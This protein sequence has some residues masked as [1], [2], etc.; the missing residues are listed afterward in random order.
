MRDTS[1]LLQYSARL[2]VREWKKFVLP[3]L[4]L[5][6]TAIVLLVTLLLSTSST[7][8]LDNQARELLGGDIV[9]ESTKPL[10]AQTTWSTLGITPRATSTQIEF[11]GT[12]QSNERT[13]PFS[14]KAVSGEYPLYGTVSLTDGPLTT[15]I[16]GAIYL[17]AAGAERLSVT[18]GS[19]VSFGNQDFTLA[20]IIKSE[21]TALLSGFRFLPQ[22][23]ITEMSFA[24]TGIDPNLLRAEYSIL[25]KTDSVTQAQ[26]SATEAL[27]ANSGGLISTRIAGENRS[28]LQRG[29]QIVADFLI[30]AILITAVL[31]AVNVYASTIYLV[32]TLRKSLA[33]L[34]ALGFT[35][36][37][38]SL[39]LATTLGYVVLIATV[40]GVLCGYGVFT[41]I[42]HYASTHYG[43]LLPTPPILWYSLICFVLL[44]SVAIASFVPAVQRTL[45]PTPKQVLSDS[46]DTT[47]TT[48]TSMR[49]LVLTTTLALLP[50]GVLASL[51]LNS[52]VEGVAI[53]GATTLVYAFIAG[54]FAFALRYAY[55]H[56][57]RFSFTI[58]S[59]ISQ[60]KADG[61]FGIISFA[62]LFV[63]L[64]ALSTLS[65]LQIA[66]ER[67]LTTDLAQSV[68]ST[69]VLDIQ[70]SQYEQFKATFP[71]VQLF[72]SIQARIKSIDSVQIQTELAKDN[73]TVDR[74]LGREFNLTARDTLLANEAVVAGKWGN[75][76]AGEISV[77]KD[78]AQRANISLGSELVFLIQGFEITGTVTS[79]RSTDSRS[80]VPF[81]F[82]VMSEA[83]LGS[84]PATYFG[85]ANYD[86]AM[87]T[88]L[89]AYV[90]SNTPNVSVLK[91]N[92]LAPLLLS[93][94]STLMVLVLIVTIPPLLI[95][96]LL[97]VTLVI[98]SFSARRREG[99]RL[100]A[101]GATRIFVL[102]QYLAET[103]SLTAAATAVAYIVSSALA[104]G[105]SQYFFKLNTVVLF[106][107]ILIIG[108]ALITVLVALVGLYL[109]ITD[110][111]PLR[112]ILSYGDN[113]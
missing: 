94:T 11:T 62:S 63:A 73:S 78:F 23:L 31:A 45:A 32:Q 104:Y 66:L 22:A 75:G 68:P 53:I 93:I 37:R 92:T 15:L 69:Y 87:Q 40:F 30:V 6:I 27:A 74:E 49:S 48:R 84:F 21:P 82:I 41:L 97:I 88:T 39:L 108:L 83:D 1:T 19:V 111:K 58:R 64:T 107:G 28:G 112:E 54:L 43:L 90:A 55:T 8:L 79:L 13:A 99:S 12:L 65:L 110:R 72:S 105:L 42:T 56:R 70:P 85:Y 95:A 80:G 76:S 109:F 86:E 59:V 50:L 51:L 10:D 77:D 98:S 9:I 16:D 91:T 2:V 103:L 113:T 26:I 34:L 81:F 61:L 4:S 3:F 36:T 18:I 44:L 25:A 29:V 67:Y 101:L 52:L 46:E 35:R 17:D 89:G 96:T 24:T 33:I 60:K 57:Q 71:E 106:D 14:V 47:P 20:G 102:R 5:S 100:R 7:I 38:L